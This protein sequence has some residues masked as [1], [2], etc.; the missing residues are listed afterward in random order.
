VLYR[1]SSFNVLRVSFSDFFSLVVVVVVEVADYFEFLSF[2]FFS[3]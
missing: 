2:Y 1:D 3:S